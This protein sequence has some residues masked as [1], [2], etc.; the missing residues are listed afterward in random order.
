MVLVNF[1]TNRSFSVNLGECSSSVSPLNCGVPQGSILAPVLYSLYMLPLGSI[2]QKHNV[3]FHCFA[4][5]IQI[6]LPVT[7][8][9]SSSVV[10]TLLD[11]L[12]EVQAWLSTNFLN[13]NK[14]KTEIV[15]FGQTNP[16]PG[17]NSVIG[18]LASY[19]HPFARNL[20]VTC[21]DWNSNLIKSALLLKWSLFSP[22]LNLKGQSMLSL[23]H[24]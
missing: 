3:S 16:L 23:H 7:T 1:L 6:Y 12:S 20:G 5:D 11:C 9:D 21:D 8:T 10:S 2:F 13:L 15:V 19:C 22:R 24:A 18:P 17:Y 14:N 4:D